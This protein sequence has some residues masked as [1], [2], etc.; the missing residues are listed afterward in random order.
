M[1]VF[2][3]ILAFLSPILFGLNYRYNFSLNYGKIKENFVIE[4][5]ALSRYDFKPILEE[6]KQGLGSITVSNASFNVDKLGF[7]LLGSKYPL[8]DDYQTKALNLTFGGIQFV[9]TIRNARSD[10]VNPNITENFIITLRYNETIKVHYNLSKPSEGYLI[11]RTIFYPAHLNGFY[12]LK[13]NSNQ[14][15]QLSEYKNYEIIEY[16][17]V[18]F[19]YK[20][21]FKDENDVFNFTMYLIWDYNI[22]IKNWELFQ[23]KTVNFLDD[24]VKTVTPKFNYKFEVEGKTFNTS[25]WVNFAEY[26]KYLIIAD[27]V[28]LNLTVLLDDRE[29]LKDFKLKLNN[30]FISSNKFNNYL[31]PDNSISTD[32]DITAADNSF[33]LNFTADFTIE[34]KEATENMWAIDRLVMNRNIRER[35]YFPSIISGPSHLYLKYMY[36]IDRSLASTQI[37]GNRTQFDRSTAYFDANI[38]EISE[39]SRNSLVFTKNA[40][41]TRGI[42]IFLPYLIKDEVCPILMRYRTTEDLRIIITDNINMPIEG[43]KVEIYY[44]GILYG[45]Y[46]SKSKVQPIAPAITDENGE[47]SIENVPGG[48]FSIKVYQNDKIVKTSSVSAYVD[49]NYVVTNIIHFPIWLVIFTC[50]N[51]SL[52]LIGITL[53]HIFKKRKV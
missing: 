4:P 18:K 20:N 7:Y 47:I 17:F 40:T 45:T 28:D 16:N 36:I 9:Q 3:L 49:V 21:F 39:V 46:M 42:K 13:N 24:K 32:F 27:N 19:N 30:Q 1:H 12:I 6:E 43:L 52:I 35:I 10:N 44:S 14:I 29:L 25:T 11:Y 22:T 50:I 41:K 23:Y 2:L 53:N 15:I 34:L 38:T 48:N 51:I 8:L 26:E 33:Y 37:V 5:Q 31:N